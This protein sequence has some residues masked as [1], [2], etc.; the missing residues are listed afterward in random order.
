MHVSVVV[1]AGPHKAAR[2]LE[3]LSHHVVN[4]AVLVPDLILVELGPV[5]PGTKRACCGERAGG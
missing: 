3:D 4:E 2:R 5:V 1:L